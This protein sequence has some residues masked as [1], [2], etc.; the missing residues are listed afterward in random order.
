MGEVYRARDTRLDRAVAVKVLTG[1]LATDPESRQ[2]FEQEARAIAALNDPHICTIHDVG[3]H[4]DHEYLVLEHLDA[5][6]TS[7]SPTS[8]ASRCCSSG[9]GYPMIATHD[10]RM[11]AIAP[12]RRRALRPRSRGP[13]STN[14]Y[15]IR[16]EEQKRLVA[17]GE[18]VRVYVPYGSEW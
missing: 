6:S 10:P 3:R 14:L 9:N 11:V 13:T 1:A 17:E 7:T 18:W 2:R 12:R 8:A 15:G 16:P 5:A 4:D